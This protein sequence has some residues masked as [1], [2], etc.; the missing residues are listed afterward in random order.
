MCF[1]LSVRHLHNSASVREVTPPAVRPTRS[2]FIPPREPRLPA[3]APRRGG[4]MVD[5][6]QPFLSQIQWEPGAWSGSR[7]LRSEAQCES[8]EEVR[9]P[10]ERAYSVHLAAAVSECAGATA[11][12]N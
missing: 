1:P 4:H 5:D 8:G 12:C 10:A 6:K 2:T 3:A 7:R 11:T 9:S